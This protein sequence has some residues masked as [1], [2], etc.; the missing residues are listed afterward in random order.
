MPL[1]QVL[2]SFQTFPGHPLSLFPPESKPPPSH[3]SFPWGPVQS[4]FHGAAKT[5]QCHSLVNS[6]PMVGFFFLFF[7]FPM[8]FDCK[9]NKTQ[10]SHYNLKVP[11]PGS[12]RA[13]PVQ[14][15]APPQPRPTYFPVS[16]WV[17]R[18]TAQKSHFQRGLP[19]S[20]T[21][22]CQIL[23]SLRPFTVSHLFIDAFVSLPR[24]ASSSSPLFHHGHEI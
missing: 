23:C 22:P 11:G 4:T 7:F 10:P 3:S 19:D 2:T 20:T 18:S 14:S 1:P 15:P 16:E 6:L 9:D 5:D 13:L 21:S 24:N 8:V 12:C 17:A